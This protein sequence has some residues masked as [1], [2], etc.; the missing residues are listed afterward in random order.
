MKA[1]LKNKQ[2]AQWQRQ[3]YDGIAHYNAKLHKCKRWR[4]RRKAR[5]Q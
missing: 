3:F 1:R 2:I 4:N 5:K